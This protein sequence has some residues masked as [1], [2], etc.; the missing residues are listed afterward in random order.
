MAG[1]FWGVDGCQS[2]TTIAAADRVAVHNAGLLTQ[3]NRLFVRGRPPD[4]LAWSYCG[5]I[6]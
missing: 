4:F 5:S 6:S 1:H 2:H 3:K